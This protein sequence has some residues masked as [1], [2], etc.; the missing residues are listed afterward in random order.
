MNDDDDD[1]KRKEYNVGVS[2]RESERPAKRQRVVEL[3]A[4]DIQDR[5]NL[6][7]GLRQLGS[8]L[9]LVSSESRIPQGQVSENFINLQR[10]LNSALE[11]AFSE[12]QSIVAQN[13]ERQRAEE[14][15]AMAEADREQNL[16]LQQ[17]FLQ[18][19]Q[20]LTERMS[21]QLTYGEQAQ[22]FEFI[23]TSINSRI[24][25]T[26]SNRGPSTTVILIGLANASYNLA[27]ELLGITISNIYQATPQITTQMVSL[28]T[29]SAMIFNYLP[30]MVRRQYTAIPYLGPLFS[31]MNSVNPVA[32]RVQNSAAIVTTVYFLLRNAGIDTTDAIANIGSSARELVTSCSMEIGRLVCSGTGI[33]SEHA[34]SIMNSLA[35]RLGNILTQRYN[36]THDS[37]SESSQSSQS[38]QSSMSSTASMSSRR[39]VDIS[40]TQHSDNTMATIQSV[41]MLLDTPVS[42]GG[43]S[44]NSNNIPGEVVEERLNAIASEDESNPIIAEAP[45]EES[46]ASDISGSESQHHWSY[47]LFGKPSNNESHDSDSSPIVGGRKY[48]RYRKTK[49]HIA[50]KYR[51]TRKHKKHTKKHTKK[52]IQRKRRTKNN[53]KRK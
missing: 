52:H 8:N 32:V 6:L 48:R 34:T 49:K 51:M 42:E 38:S 28:I 37:A 33:I 29:A 35:G 41:R 11:A 30:E 44:I 19:L 3:P 9:A 24:S 21:Q 17:R 23:L 18:R 40:E 26:I 39:T 14:G 5:Q 7:Q 10:E 27:L 16:Q 46:L 47:W 45:L 31:L 36:E 43:I 2:E 1:K 50:K 53:K 22:M 12:A 13:E 15:E 25:E 4:I 20:P